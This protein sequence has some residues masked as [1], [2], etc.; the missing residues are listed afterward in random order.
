M[1]SWWGRPEDF[2]CR[3]L[4]RPQIRIGND[5]GCVGRS[6]HSQPRFSSEKVYGGT[7]K[8]RVDCLAVAACRACKTGQG[9]TQ[10]H[11]AGWKPTR[12]QSRWAPETAMPVRPV[13]AVPRKRA[14]GAHLRG[15]VRRPRLLHAP[16]G[17]ALVA[18]GIAIDLAC[19]RTDRKSTRLNTSH[20][21]ISY[22]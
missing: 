4:A 11:P 21:G 16:P 15:E 18:P 14:L 3:T 6:R 2:G 19:R 13:P 8:S 12:K 20:L 7:G 5:V 9:F 17:A 22:A 1:D 10:R